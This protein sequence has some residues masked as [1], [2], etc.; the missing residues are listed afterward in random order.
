[1]FERMVVV[2]PDKIEL[3]DVDDLLPD[4]IA[5]MCRGNA[6]LIAHFLI[7]FIHRDRQRKERS[8]SGSLVHGLSISSSKGPCS[9]RSTIP[10]SQVPSCGSEEVRA[11]RCSISTSI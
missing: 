4:A 2:R 11:M 5:G 9:F 8:Q 1:M 6:A 3:E 7:I 10:F